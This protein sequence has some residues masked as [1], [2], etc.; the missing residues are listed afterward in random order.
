MTLAASGDE[1][2]QEAAAECFCSAASFDGGRALLGPV[3]ESGIIFALMESKSQAARSAAARQVAYAKLGMISSALSSDSDDVTKLLNVSLDLITASNSSPTHGNAP[4]SSAKHKQKKDAPGSTLGGPKSKRGG[5]GGMD[6]LKGG[7]AIADSERAVEVLSFLV[8]KTKVKEELCYGSARCPKALSRLCRAAENVSGTSP[9]AYGLAFLF[10]SLCVSK[11]EEVKESFKGKD[12]TYEQYQQLKQLNDSHGQGPKEDETD[13]KDTADAA[14]RRS[15]ALAE[16][17]CVVSLKKIAEDAS[18]ATRERVA[19]CFRRLA[20]DPS[21]R[22]LIVQQGGLSLLINMASVPKAAGKGEDAKKEQQQE[23][24]KGKGCRIEARHAIAKTLVT[25]NP[26]LLAEAQTMGSVP[27]LITMCRD[28]ESLN[29]QQFEG[30]MALTNLASLDNV[31]NRI[32]AEKGI[33][34]FQYLQ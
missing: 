2:A 32:V 11:E 27:A 7:A 9:I 31:K 33:S 34:C 23:E 21:N 24:E 8:S 22:G 15:H 6:G 20:T 30:L 29:L 18:P 19:L 16:A 26:N 13:M 4:S 1:V 17:G 14:K 28:H 5:V 10:S 12:M 25:T 3:V